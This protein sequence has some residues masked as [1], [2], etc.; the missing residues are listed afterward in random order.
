M[1]IVLNVY[2]IKKKM[3]VIYKNKVWKVLIP[4][5]LKFP[6][7]CIQNLLIERGKKRII[8]NIKQIKRFQN[9]KGL[10]KF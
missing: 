4:K 6:K 5:N 7:Y 3:N 1:Q 10:D 2:G 8:T 9:F